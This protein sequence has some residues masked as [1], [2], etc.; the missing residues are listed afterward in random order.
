MISS[1]TKRWLKKNKVHL[2]EDWP[3]KSPD[4]NIIE[5]VWGYLVKTVYY[6]KGSY[7]NLDEL[8]SAILAAWI[9]IP[10]TLLDKLY[11][12]MDAR[13]T[14]VMKKDGDLTHY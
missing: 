6:E 4:M 10:Q 7:K 2:L 14:E 3:P 13:L 8:K 1:E 11:A 12:S 5:N 9:S